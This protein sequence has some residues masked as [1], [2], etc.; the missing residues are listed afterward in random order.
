MHVCLFILLNEF[1]SSFRCHGRGVSWA[2][3]GVFV[4]EGGILF[5]FYHVYFMV[6]SL[7]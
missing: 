3:L 5:I 6:L 2:E 1:S 4:S 7:N